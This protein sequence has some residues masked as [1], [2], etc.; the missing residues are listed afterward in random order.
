MQQRRRFA[1]GWALWVF[2]LIFLPI[3]LSLGVWQLDRA[4]QKR[5]LQAQTEQQRQQPAIPLSELQT[6]TD[7]AW[8]ALQLTGQFD[9]E[10]IWLLDNRTRNGQAG[11]EV[12]QLFHDQPSNQLLV[13]NRGWLAWPDRR[14]L[15]GVPTPEGNLDLWAE[16]LPDAEQGFRL[17]SPETAGWPRLIAHLDPAV[18]AEQAGRALPPWTARLQPG[19]AGALR[20][21]WPA[22]SMSASQHHGYAVQWFALAGALLILFIWAGCRPEPRGK[23]Q[24]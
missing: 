2:T 1:P 3:L 19:S 14:Q 9:P 21:E 7:P 18:L 15:P 22:L 20:L 6:T 10:R 4:G 24:P 12:L 16:V 8:R 11:V 13:I 23:Q 17:H 5:L